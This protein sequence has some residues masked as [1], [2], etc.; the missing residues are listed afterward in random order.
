MRGQ[1]GA[2]SQEVCT[3]TLARVCWC[4][5]PG[6]LDGGYGGPHWETQMFRWCE[7]EGGSDGRG[8]YLTPSGGTGDGLGGRRTVPMASGRAMRSPWCIPGAGKGLKFAP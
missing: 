1:V 3:A 6:R 8:S 2:W 5:C 7:C 4:V